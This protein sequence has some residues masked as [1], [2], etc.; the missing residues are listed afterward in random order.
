MQLRAGVLTGIDDAGDF[1]PSLEDLVPERNG[2]NTEYACEY[3]GPATCCWPTSERE[4]H[5]GSHQEHFTYSPIV[6]VEKRRIGVRQELPC[7]EQ[8]QCNLKHAPLAKE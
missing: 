7:G 8:A 6:C 4:G 1:V 5:V 2:R 3:A